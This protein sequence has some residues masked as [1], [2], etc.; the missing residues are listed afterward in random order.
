M[1][2][3]LREEVKVGGHLE[4]EMGRRVLGGVAREGVLRRIDK[5]RTGEKEVGVRVYSRGRIAAHRAMQLFG[6]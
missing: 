2:E 1:L 4:L 3:I 6:F 5:E